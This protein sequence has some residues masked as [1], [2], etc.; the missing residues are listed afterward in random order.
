MR[1]ADEARATGP[2]TGCGMAEAG[3]WDSRATASPTPVP[4]EVR[5]GTVPCA[6]RVRVVSQAVGRR[7]ASTAAGRS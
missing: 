7:A 4:G 1:D 2:M 6:G 5:V 3:L